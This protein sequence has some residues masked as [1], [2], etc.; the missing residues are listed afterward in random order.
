MQHP[1]PAIT[2][3]DVSFRWPDGRQVLNHATVTFPEGRTALI[4]RNGAGKTTLLQLIAHQIQ[5]A[6]GVVQTHGEIAHLAQHA[7]LD[8]ATSVMDLLGITETVT[9]LRAIE[10]GSTRAEDFDALGDTGWDIEE[11]TGAL[12]HR[13][14]LHI[15]LDRKVGELSGGEAGLVALAGVQ[16]GRAEITLLDEPTNDL[17]EE[18][19]RRV[20]ELLASWRGNLVV[21]SH[22]VELLEVMDAVAELRDGQLTTF[23]GSYASWLEWLDAEQQAARR[24]VSA[25]KQ[26]LHRERSD[27]LAQERTIATRRRMGGT[28]AVTAGRHF[29]L[30][31]PHLGSAGP[32]GVGTDRTERFRE[33]DAPASACASRHLP[34]RTVAPTRDLPRGPRRV[35]AAEARRRPRVIPARAGSAGGTTQIT[36]RNP[37]RAGALL[38]S[39]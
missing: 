14:G 26:N 33:D 5:P 16:L 25:A 20:Y 32:G 35:P 24:D 17:D 34:R 15:P 1:T 28:A 23:G 9:A 37:K 12:L 2:F 36:S 22:D 19:R 38:A 6:S 10:N 8:P 11:R 7:S 4:G 29:H 27:R 13:L 3:N 21:V 30:R 31:G 39:R 18:H